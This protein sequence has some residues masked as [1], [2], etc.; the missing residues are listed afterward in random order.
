MATP[1]S[2]AATQQLYT[3]PATGGHVP[4]GQPWGPTGNYGGYSVGPGPHNPE[5]YLQGPGTGVPAF[6]YQ[7]Q[8]G[9]QPPFGSVAQHPPTT[10][11]MT[12][13][14]AGAPG[15]QPPASAA[16]AAAAT[17]TTPTSGEVKAGGEQKATDGEKKA[18]DG[19]KKATDGEKK[20]G[21]GKSFLERLNLGSFFVN[22]RYAGQSSESKS[23]EQ[24]AE[25]GKTAEKKEPE[26]A[27]DQGAKSSA[28]PAATPPPPA[29][30]AGYGQQPAGGQPPHVG[31]QSPHVGGQ[32]PHVGGQPPHVGGQPPHVGYQHLYP[33]A[34][35]PYTPAPGPHTPPTSGYG[36]APAYGTHP[37]AEAPGVTQH[38]SRSVP[39]EGKESAPMQYRSGLEQRVDSHIQHMDSLVD[40]GVSR[41][42]HLDSL[43]RKDLDAHRQ[44]AADCEGFLASSPNPQ[45][46]ELLAEDRTNQRA[47][48]LGEISTEKQ[49]GTDTQQT[50]QQSGERPMPQNAPGQDPYSL[51]RQGTIDGHRDSLTAQLRG[52]ELLRPS[53]QKDTGV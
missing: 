20:S 18:T 19:E 11:Y 26:K 9:G 52:M 39:P 31:G 8:H 23:S 27:P 50:A 21:G 3:P 16:P 47:R 53:G 35:P 41:H 2:P 42:D 15:A 24:T 13:F 10:Q 51:A 12:Q 49:K 34:M 7:Q 17:T 36:Q 6:P 33:S 48:I 14:P 44:H 5:T 1:L 40:G 38:D 4:T 29:P 30:G 28:A 43:V 37:Q 46:R 32:S 22:E 25:K 45:T